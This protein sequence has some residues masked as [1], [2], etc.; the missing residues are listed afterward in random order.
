MLLRRFRGGARARRGIICNA[1]DMMRRTCLALAALSL[2]CASLFAQGGMTDQQIIDYVVS[3]QEKGTPQSDIVAY[4]MRRGVRIEQIRSMQKKLKQQADG[5]L[6][7]KDLVSDGTASKYG[8]SRSRVPNG[9]AR[10]DDDAQNSALGRIRAPEEDEDPSMRVYDDTDPEFAEMRG[11]IDE[12]YPDSIELVIQERMAKRAK[13]KIFGRDI[14]NNRLLSFEPNMN[15]ATPQNYVLG[16]EDEVI[17]DVWGASQNTFSQ[18]VSPDGTVTVEG[19]GPVRLSGLTVA[20]ANERVRSL[21]GSR[22][23]QSDIRLTVGQ[24][25]A[26]SVNVMGEVRTPGTYTLSAFASVFHALYVAGGI[27]EVGTLRDIKVFRKGREIGSVDVY[28]FILNGRLEG[29]VRLEDGDVVAVGPY[30]CLVNITGKVKRPMFYEMKSGESL[31]SLLAYSGGFTGDAYRKSVRVVRKSGGELSVHNIAEF[32]MSG[33]RM[34]DADSVSVDSALQRFS[35]MAEIKGAVFRP[36]M[37]DVDGGAATVKQL[38]ERAEGL[39]EY[40]FRS[41]AVMHRLK[42]DRS[43]EALSVDIGGIMDGTAPDIP[44]RNGDVLLVPSL[45][46][47]REER[48]LKIYGEVYYPGTYKYASNLTLEDF[49]LMAGGLRDAASVIKV[50]VSRRNADPKAERPS[51]NISSV[52]SFA[53]AEGLAVGG[54]DTF[55]LMPFDEVYVRKSPAYNEQQNVEVDGEVLFRGTYTLSSKNERLSEIIKQAGGV[56]SMGYVRGAR[57]ERRLNDDERAR[58]EDV[59]MTAKMTASEEDSISLSKVA[60]GSTY[61]VG[62]E[63]DKALADPGGEYD[64]VLRQGDR[65]VVPQLSNTVRISGNVMSPNTVPFHAGRDVDYYVS[66]AGGY[67]FRSKKS[68]TYIVY[69]NGMVAKAG[70]SAKPEPGCEIIVPSKHR[71]QTSLAQWISMGTGIASIATMIATLANVIAK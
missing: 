58:M 66:Q 25:R 29:N 11:A 22:Y 28:D 24:T 51:D 6:N 7:A 38:V 3:E 60:I 26:I 1:M 48:E 49:I 71:S 27:S 30:D 42:S 13:R 33:F 21:L 43:L 17:I 5:A 37:Y 54:A 39:T 14:F 34:A 46:Q 35:N 64:V 56:N 9:N 23:R 36:G 67:G 62:I 63:L 19:A 8:R 61:S 50:D 18:T 69:M 31:A 45:E 52:F 70:R 57:L 16:P 68:H 32:D 12:M 53:L 44:L 40:A 65:I 41:H 4:L 47:M 2:S 59:L 55:R 20:K 10:R 15:I